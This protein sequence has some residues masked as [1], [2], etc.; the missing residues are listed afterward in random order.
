MAMIDWVTA[1]LPCNHDTNKLFVGYIA[2]VNKDGV[3]WCVDKRLSIEGSY[4]STIQIKSNTDSK[5]WISGNPT[6]FL[7]GHNIFGSS[8]LVYIMKKFFDELL[9]RNELGLS[10]TLQQYQ[11]I[12]KGE[13]KITHVDVN[14]SW[15]LNNKFEVLAW[16]KA[17]GNFANLKHRGRGQYAGDT[18]YFGKHSRRWAVKCYSKGH[19]IIAKGHQ[20][21]KEIQ[22]PELIDWADKALRIELVMRSMALKS[23]GYDIASKWTSDTPTVLLYNYFL[24][25]LELSEN[26]PLQANDLIT[27]KP[28]LKLVYEYWLSGKD[29]REILPR[30]TFY[31]YR[32]ELMVHNIDISI[33]QDKTK[34]NNTIPLIRYLEASPASIPQWAYDKGLVA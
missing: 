12:Q 19:E 18:L 27:L 25:N 9:K 30:P 5:I 34:D 10:P 33:V 20:L 28:R 8:D 26:M 2:S 31:R 22:I 7:Q 6:K 4:S 32:K 3:E 24:K 21:P 23:I 14:Q 16:I 13:Y 15:L 17:A 11:D 1:I 29:L